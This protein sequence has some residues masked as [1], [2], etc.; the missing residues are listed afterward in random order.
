MN[1]KYALKRYKMFEVLYQPIIF[2]LWMIAKLLMNL[3][4]FTTCDRSDFK[5][6][7]LSF[8]LSKYYG[9]N[10]KYFMLLILQNESREV[11]DLG[12]TEANYV[13]LSIYLQKLQT[14]AKTHFSLNKIFMVLRYNLRR[15]RLVSTDTAT[16][17]LLCRSYSVQN[18]GFDQ[19]K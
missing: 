11:Q 14:L 4:L 17:K 8:S 2:E 16:V 7:R 19:F 9:W 10:S 12:E 5:K 13:N 15:E 6:V 3:N 1:R 18:H